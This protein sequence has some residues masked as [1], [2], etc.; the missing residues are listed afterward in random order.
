MFN[1]ANL[2]LIS[3]DSSEIISSLIEKKCQPFPTEFIK[4][5]KTLEV[6]LRYSAARHFLQHFSWCLE[7]WQTE[8]LC[9]NFKAISTSF[10][11]MEWTYN[12]LQSVLNC[13]NVHSNMRS[14]AKEARMVSVPLSTTSTRHYS[15][16]NVVASPGAA[17]WVHN[18]FIVGVIVIA[19]VGK[20]TD[21]AKPHSICFLFFFYH[22]QLIKKIYLQI[23]LFF[24]ARQ[25][26]I[27]QS[28]CKISSNCVKNLRVM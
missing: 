2:S 16:Q 14:N 17:E 1:F 4:V 22:Y 10:R 3:K 11:Y 8:I 15:G 6:C 13:L 18:K 21:N 20:S 19:I 5:S 25:Q 28:D 9:K 7:T 24:K 26:Q 12:S 23:C 27:S